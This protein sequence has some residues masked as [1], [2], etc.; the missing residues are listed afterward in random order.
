MR[1]TNTGVVPP[2]PQ[3][4]QDTVT[5]VVLRQPEQGIITGVVLPQPQL[6][7]GI[8]TGVVLPQPAQPPDVPRATIVRS[9]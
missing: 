3:S 7:Q 8:T 6:I 5:G 2:Q 1:G 9:E 4:K